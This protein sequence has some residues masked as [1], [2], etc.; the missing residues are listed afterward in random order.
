M[1]FLLGNSNQ[2][3]TGR[4]GTPPIALQR[5]R[6]HHYILS[7]LLGMG[8]H[9][10]SSRAGRV[11]LQEAPRL[12]MDWA[13]IPAG[14]LQEHRPIRAVCV[15]GGMLAKGDVAIDQGRPDRRKL[16]GAKIFL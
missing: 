4:I 15:S 5:M 1:G 2:P 8:P 6:Q 9:R 12:L 10:C 7:K 14:K 16:G 11:T 3:S 13:K